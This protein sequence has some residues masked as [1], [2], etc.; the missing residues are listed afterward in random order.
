[1][2]FAVMR[3][4]LQDGDKELTLQAGRLLDL[5]A[6]NGPFK[7]YSTE[8]MRAACEQSIPPHH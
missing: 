2:C 4:F 8:A 7:P 5:K 6:A 1:M 3:L